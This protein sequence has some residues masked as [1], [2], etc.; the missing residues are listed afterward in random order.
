MIFR[1]AI[2]DNRVT[3]AALVPPVL[4]ALASSLCSPVDLPKRGVSGWRRFPV[5]CVLAAPVHRGGVQGGRRGDDGDRTGIGW[6]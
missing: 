3:R 4:F 2:Q 1:R 6:E 5:S